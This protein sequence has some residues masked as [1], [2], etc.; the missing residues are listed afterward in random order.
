VGI[1]AAAGLVATLRA[2]VIAV[3]M[4]GF[5]LAGWQLTQVGWRPLPG[6]TP[7]GTDT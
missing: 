1:S 7:S 4:L 5:L 6:K 3:A 2:A